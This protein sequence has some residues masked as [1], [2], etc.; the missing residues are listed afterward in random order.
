M[1]GPHRLTLVDGSS[2]LSDTVIVE[3]EGPIFSSG[4]VLANDDDEYPADEKIITRHNSHLLKLYSFQQTA[5]HL[6]RIHRS[7][8]IVLRGSL[9]HHSGSYIELT[10]I[11]YCSCVTI[12]SSVLWRICAI[13][14]AK[15][16]LHTIWKL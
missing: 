1:S 5:Q 16:C 15:T 4:L 2:N 8:E 10:S 11:K 12:C 13:L 6:S 9:I 3:K 7:S 14:A